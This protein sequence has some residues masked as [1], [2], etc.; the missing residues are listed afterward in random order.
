MVLRR[1]VKRL[2]AWAGI[3]D[4]KGRARMSF[5][6]V[7]RVRDEIDNGDVGYVDGE[8]TAVVG[9]VFA[10]GWWWCSVSLIP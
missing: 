9:Y 4:C 3:L 2:V 8:S 6:D 10:T 5:A 1:G 7:A